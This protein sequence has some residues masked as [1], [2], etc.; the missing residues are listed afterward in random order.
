MFSDNGIFKNR[1][2]FRAENIIHYP[3]IHYPF[4]IILHV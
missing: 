2:D 3:V 4:N 1:K